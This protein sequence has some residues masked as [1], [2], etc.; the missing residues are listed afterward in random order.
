MFIEIRP[1]AG[2]D[3]AY[4]FAQELADSFA[5]YCHRNSYRWKQKT[6]DGRMFIYQISDDAIPILSHFCG[7]HKIQRIPKKHNKRHTSTV[8]V[9]IVEELCETKIILDK[10]DVVE[11][12]YRGT[13]AGGQHR[14]KVSTA[15]RMTHKGSGITVTTE[16]GR[17]Q[18]ANRKKVKKRLEEQLEIELAKKQQNI[19]NGE[20]SKIASSTARSEKTFTH[21]EQRNT[22][23]NHDTGR[24]WS[25]KNFRKGLL[26]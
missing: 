9:V 18:A 26:A 11:Q 12:F 1:G 20:R 21:N 14:N 6:S 19:V 4:L 25:I 5:T 8:T 7:T 15:V 3:D 16:R 24:K 2:G 13:G 23:T 17:S 10:D 22:I